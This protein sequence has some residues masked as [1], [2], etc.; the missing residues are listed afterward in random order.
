MLC[1]KLFAAAAALLLLGTAP[2]YPTRTTGSFKLTLSSGPFISG[3]R[4]PI[5]SL[6]ANG[7]L[8]LSLVGPGAIERGQFVAP[9]VDEP[10]TTTLIAAARGALAYNTVKVVP[11]PSPHRALI[12]VAAYDNGVALHDPNTF[13][14]LGY[15]PIGGPPGDV[16]FARS[17]DL[18]VP[19]TDGDTITHVARAPWRMRAVQGVPAGNEVAVDD[20][21]GNV[22]VSNRD[23]NGLGALT[24]ITPDGKVTRVTTGDTAEG[25]AIDGT[26]GI[27]YV[28]NVND[29]TVAQ[30]DA[31]SMTVTRKMRSVE[32]TFG[33]ALDAKAQ[34]LYVV[35]NTSPSMHAGGGFVAAIDLRAP[36]TPIVRKSKP[37]TFPLG[38]ALEEKRKRLFVTDESA[39]E[40]YV[41]NANTLRPLHAPLST[42]RT[43]WRPR[44]AGSRL[45]VPCARA[46]TVDVFDLNTL[47]RIKGAPFATGG[48]PL[49]VAL[50][51]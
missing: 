21:T 50:W 35:S 3:S 48:F 41:M 32:R 15:A 13:A 39:D 36:S 44:I 46:N 20:R 40:V 37:M 9:L 18:Y 11:P 43:P 49:S 5:D 38:I 17:G 30:V 25:L 22:F 4:L 8:A 2:H 31:R 45:Y 42:C 14:L 29:N 12:A 33:I 34:R 10:T 47:R 24:R 28:G 16:A 26:R 51:P 23:V 27:V 19:D 7:P 1:G 6:G